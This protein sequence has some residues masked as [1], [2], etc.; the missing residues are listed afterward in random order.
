MNNDTRD[1]AGLRFTSIAHAEG[2]ANEFTEGGEVGRIRM[3][4]GEYEYGE[5]KC[6]DGRVRRIVQVWD[7]ASARAV[8]DALPA[9][10]YPV[11]QGHPDVPEVAAKYPNKAAVGW[12]TADAASTFRR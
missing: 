11:Y 12:V 7:E 8:R 3:P 9:E 5:T 4:Y 2:F 6:P 10:G 1:F